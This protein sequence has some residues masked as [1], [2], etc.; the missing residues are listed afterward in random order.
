MGNALL[1]GVSGLNSHQK[2]L[3][4][5]GN[6][7]ANLNSTAY[8]AQRVLF[9]DLLYQTVS[10][11]SSGANGLIGGINPAQV[12]SGSQVG[13][14][15]SNFTQ[16]NL[17]PT[18]Q[19]LDFAIDGDGFFVVS[20][21]GSPKYTRAGSFAVDAD[22]LLIDPST[23]YRVQRFG[24]AGEPNGVD[25]SFQTAGDLNIHVPFGASIPGKT[26]TKVNLVGNLSSDS[27]GP[28][29][30]VLST[31]SPWLTGG[32]PATA[33]TLLSALD[34]AVSPYAAGDSLQFTGTNKD[35]TPV[36]STFN[37]DATTTVGDLLN[38]I[39]TAFPDGTA[40]IDPDGN[41]NMTSNTVGEALFSIQIQDVA[42]NAGA[43][44]YDTHPFTVSENGRD[45]TKVLG[46]FEVFDIRG[47]AHTVTTTLQKQADNSWNLTATVADGEGTILDGQINNIRFNDDGSFLEAGGVGL[48]D[49]N[50]SFTWRDLAQP[51]VITLGFGTQGSYDGMTQLSASSTTS[52]FQDGYASGTLT[53]VRMSSNGLME[54]VATNGRSIP[55]AQLAIAT[56]RNPSGMTRAGAN[57]YDTSLASGDAEIGTALSGDRGTVKSNYLERSN[58]DIALEFTQ[59]I[60]AQR[61][62]SANARTITV[63]D[64]ILQELTGLI[65]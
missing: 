60:T 4:V 64:E 33:A 27:V 15:S 31:T 14:I 63:T 24:D 30:E 37:V 26:T 34:S 29:A 41:I 62:F 32:V 10:A 25:P 28:A 16:G 19:D 23:G 47:K 38:A 6:N 44:R 17:E 42:G 43:M 5:I 1:T 18:G 36:N 51:Q 65:R 22:G 61:G 9:S 53:E 2:M 58:V 11:A 56:F 45:G 13:Q 39:S 55:L 35:G 50:L 52:A 59:L 48:A 40:T 20:G 3:E 54:G 21:G 8:K 7:L 46:G 49:L 12:G 57:Y